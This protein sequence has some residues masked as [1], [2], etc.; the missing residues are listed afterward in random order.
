[1]IKIRLILTA[2]FLSILLIAC[3]NDSNSTAPQAEQKQASTVA[4]SDAKIELGMAETA[5]SD[6]LGT[7]KSTQ[8]RTI[9][10]LTI[11]HT[12][13]ADKS[14]TVSVQFINGEVKFSHFFAK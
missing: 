13:W 10:A 1:M 8:T 7:P 5:V 11:T 6:L 4:M 12:E 14:G 2:F 9:E 3:S